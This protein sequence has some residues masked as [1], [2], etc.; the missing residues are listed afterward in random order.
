MGQRHWWAAQGA[1][2]IVQAL[3]ERSWCR[4][5][6]NQGRTVVYAAL[7]RRR[8]NHEILVRKDAEVNVKTTVVRR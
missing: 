7:E 1:K 4:N 3:L 5:E 2:A 6:D 8:F